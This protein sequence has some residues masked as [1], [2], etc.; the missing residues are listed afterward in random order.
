MTTAGG[1]RARG[2]P[3]PRYIAPYRK[4]AAVL[5]LLFAVNTAFQIIAPRALSRFIDA[6]ESGGA[7]K[8]A[9]A[10]I[11]L[12]V[13]FTLLQECAAALLSYLSEALGQRMTDDYRREVMAHYLGI[14]MEAHGKW[15]SGEVMTRLDE[16]VQGLYRYYHILFF[17]LTA[18]GILL[19]SVLL[20]LALGSPP[21][22]GMLLIISL[23]SIL[24]FKWIQDRGVSKYERRAKAAAE[25]NGIMKEALDNAVEIRA[26]AAEGH[27]EYKLRLAMKKRFRE[28]FPA[29]LMYGNLWSASTIMQGLVLAASLAI[30]MW[31]WGDGSISM[32]TVFLI[33]TYTEL[34]VGPLQDF[35]N[36]MGELQDAR[37][38][39]RRVENMMGMPAGLRHGAKRLDRGA[40]AL[41][42]RDVHFAYEGGG[43]VLRG[44]N[45]RV[46]AGE[47]VCVAGETGSGK[48]T[49]MGLVARLY[50][51]PRGEITLGGVDLRELDPQSLRDSIACLTQEPQI[52]HGTIRENITLFSQRYGDAAIRKAISDAGLDEW[53]KKFPH[54]LDTDLTLGE[55]NLSAGEAQLIAIIRLALKDP[56]LVLLDEMTARL[57]SAMEYKVLTA[58]EALCRGRTVLSIAHKSSAMAWMD[59]TVYLQ[60]GMI[61]GESGRKGADA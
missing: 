61:A 9:F 25:F 30:G 60:N 46:E 23:L 35:R 52:L 12:Y 57:D 29:S 16:D 49:L 39:M 27:A 47:K 28:S 19:L 38:K 22:S 1:R 54:G 42:V 10:M 2:F 4:R 32:G 58:M 26:F 6:L 41:E 56:A 48:S 36:H 31:L 43:E 44:V 37:A 11:G 40:H 33:F 17:K 50:E 55:S 59:R 20:V 14:G 34:V 18:S 7:L 5:A 24:V 8:S 3:L 13:V 45:L 21:L 53:F 51:Y 15:N